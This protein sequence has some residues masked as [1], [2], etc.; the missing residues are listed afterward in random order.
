MDTLKKVAEKAGKTAA[1]LWHLPPVRDG[2]LTVLVRLGLG[3]TVTA[4]VVAAADA[5]AQ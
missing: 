1:W 4:I 2:L 3:S 5:L